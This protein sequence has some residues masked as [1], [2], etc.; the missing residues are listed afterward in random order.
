MSQCSRRAERTR[1]PLAHTTLRHSRSL[2]LARAMA[3]SCL[4]Q[5]KQRGWYAIYGHQQGSFV[6]IAHTC[7]AACGE[8]HQRRRANEE[9]T[10]RALHGG[11][12]VCGSALVVE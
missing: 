2:R 9:D 6:S 3:L 7:N 8:R 11:I 4:H 1:L 10:S 12:L 5:E